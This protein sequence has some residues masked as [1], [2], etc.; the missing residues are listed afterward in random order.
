MTDAPE[1]WRERWLGAIKAV[2]YELRPFTLPTKDDLA[3]AARA[4]KMNAEQLWT[5]ARRLA[6]EIVQV[7]KSL[8][9]LRALMVLTWVC[10]WAGF[11]W[12]EFG[13]F[14]KQ[15]LQMKYSTQRFL[16]PILQ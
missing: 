13:E 16:D 2:G 8:N 6:P 10:G 12:L 4:T 1:N 3:K 5:E 11:I 9:P 15:R 7:I 14:R